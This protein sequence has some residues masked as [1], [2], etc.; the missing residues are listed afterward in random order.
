MNH[1]P[2]PSYTCNDSVYGQA[3]LCPLHAAAP[4]L[5]ELLGRVTE[6]LALRAMADHKFASMNEKDDIDLARAAIAKV[7]GGSR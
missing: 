7:R 2:G 4:E 1:T 6:R 5:L 3:S